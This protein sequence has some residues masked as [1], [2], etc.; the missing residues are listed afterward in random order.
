MW[1]LCWPLYTGGIWLQ[2]QTMLI[3]LQRRDNSHVH[4]GTAGA[5]LF[6]CTLRWNSPLT[7]TSRWVCTT[8]LQCFISAFGNIPWSF[9][10]LF[11]GPAEPVIFH[12]TS[13]QHEP[14]LF[15]PLFL[16]NSHFFSQQEE[17]WIMFSSL[18]KILLLCSSFTTFGLSPSCDF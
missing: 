10:Y 14:L 9:M 8:L 4:T 17:R 7:G 12:Q 3:L 18:F 11:S 6:N 5:E 15:G 13:V 16:Q 1:I 2:K